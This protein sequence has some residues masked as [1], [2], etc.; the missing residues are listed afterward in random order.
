M[1]ESLIDV[2]REASYE[3]QKTSAMGK[4]FMRIKWLEDN[5]DLWWHIPSKRVGLTGEQRKA[6]RRVFKAMVAANLY[7]N[8]VGF[9]NIGMMNYMS[10]IRKE[11]G[12]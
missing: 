1:I 11:K 8:S 10:L 2:T 12:E 6:L 5:K 4:K 9:M 7:S 3:V